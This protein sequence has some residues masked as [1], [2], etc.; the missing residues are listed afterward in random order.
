METS[1]RSEFRILTK[2]NNSNRSQVSETWEMISN[3]NT[4]KYTWEIKDEECS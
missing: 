1:Q 3:S 4:N 2:C